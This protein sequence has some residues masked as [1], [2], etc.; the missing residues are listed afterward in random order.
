MVIDPAIF[1]LIAMLI[2]SCDFIQHRSQDVFY[3]FTPTHGYRWHK[4][5]ADTAFLLEILPTLNEDE[6]SRLIVSQSHD[7]IH[8]FNGTAESATNQLITTIT[9]YGHQIKARR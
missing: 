4:L 8:W 9:R 2:Q 6:R 3:W 7:Q 5:N 1:K